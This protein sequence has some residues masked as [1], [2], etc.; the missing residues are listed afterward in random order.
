MISKIRIL[1]KYRIFTSKI[2]KDLN[3]VVHSGDRDTPVVNLRGEKL[4]DSFAEIFNQRPMANAPI[5]SFDRRN[6]FED[7]TWY[8][9]IIL[10]ILKN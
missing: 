5:Y 7:P 3:K 8:F 4:Y 9:Y 1:K 10:H 6:V 2:L